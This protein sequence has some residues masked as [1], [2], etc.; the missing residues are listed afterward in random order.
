M[1]QKFIDYNKHSP[2]PQDYDAKGA[3]VLN[4]APVFSLGN[5]SKSTHEIIFDHNTFKPAPTNYNAKSDLIKKHGA[6][7][8]SSQRQDLTETEKTPAPNYYMSASAA[9]FAAESNP[10]CKI[11][12]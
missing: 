2:G 1:S 8:G 4:K 5:K 10:R 7:I 11:G 12:E 6:F 9:D 3:K